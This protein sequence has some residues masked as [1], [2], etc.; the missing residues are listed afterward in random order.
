MGQSLVQIYVHAVW[1]TKHRRPLLKSPALRE[2]LFAYMAGICWNQK[3][4]AILIGGA[5]DHCHLLFRLGKTIDVSRLIRE[6]KKE[7]SRWAKS[8]LLMKNFYWQ[9]GYGAFSISP[10]HVEQLKE[11]IARQEQHH[12]KVTYKD[13]FRALC[14]KYG[15]E[16]DER[17]AWE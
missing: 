1:S 8:E 14:K 6:I 15:L 9:S 3:S 4:P 12:R 5:D 11:Y 10:G 13:E 16:V 7:A 17:Y 2:R